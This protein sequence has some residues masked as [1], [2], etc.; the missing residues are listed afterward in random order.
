VFQLNRRQQ[1]K[2]FKRWFLWQ[3]D[4][5]LKARCSG[6]DRGSV[7]ADDSNPRLYKINTKMI[8]LLIR[9][10]FIHPGGNSCA[11]GCQK[12]HENKNRII[13]GQCISLIE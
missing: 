4:I 8:H 11:I 3:R 13:N 2:L 10:I 6:R 5:F 9:S 7:H 1:W 12:I